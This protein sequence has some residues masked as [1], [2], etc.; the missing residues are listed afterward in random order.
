MTKAL[1][2]QAREAEFV[3]QTYKRQPVVFVKG[4]GTQY[5]AA[6]AEFIGPKQ[7]KLRYADGKP[8]DIVGP[9]IFLASDLA[10]FVTGSIVMADGGY[11]TV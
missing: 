7:L 2:I 11:L 3:L 5:V 1:D 6:T 8:E 9:A 4:A 10:G